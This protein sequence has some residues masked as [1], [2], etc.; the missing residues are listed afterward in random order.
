MIGNSTC[1][2]EEVAAAVGY[3]GYQLLLQ[4]LQGKLR[5]YAPAVPGQEK[6]GKPVGNNGGRSHWT[7][8]G[9]GRIKYACP[10]LI[11]SMCVAAHGEGLHMEWSGKWIKPSQEM[12]KS[13]LYLSGN[14]MAGKMGER[15]LPKRNYG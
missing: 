5:L 10:A 13:A 4:E 9:S 3:S 1:S 14:L 12:G 11:N 8:G 7:A 15:R 6:S 2:I